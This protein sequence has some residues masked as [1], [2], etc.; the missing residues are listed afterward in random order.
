KLLIATGAMPRRLPLAAK[1]S[2]RVAYLRSFADALRIRGH[3]KPGSHIAIVGG[4]FIGLELAASA[5]KRGAEVTVI[6]AQARI[7]MRGVPEEIAEVVADRHLAEGMRLCCGR[8]I[9][10]IS[11]EGSRVVVRL[12]DEA[13][14]ADCVVIGVGAVPVT[15]LAESAGLALDNGIAVD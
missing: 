2:D 11:E 5:R 15:A 12:T 13:I 10:K 4:G 3:L 1:A 14:E 8:G 9:Q 6:E 7:L